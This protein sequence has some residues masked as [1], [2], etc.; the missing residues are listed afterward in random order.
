MLHNLVFS[1]KVVVGTQAVYLVLPYVIQNPVCIRQC[2]WFSG[3][4][5]IRERERGRQVPDGAAATDRPLAAH[6]RF[7]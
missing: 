7:H 1:D 3:P 6:S 4:V 2:A 5:C